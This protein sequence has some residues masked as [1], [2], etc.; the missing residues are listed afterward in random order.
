M[1]QRNGLYGTRL[2]RRIGRQDSADAIG[3]SVKI[4]H[5][6]ADI[7]CSV[8]HQKVNHR[9]PCSLVDLVYNATP[10]IDTCF[11]SRKASRPSIP[12]SRPHPLCYTP[13]KGAVLT[14]G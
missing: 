10:P 12:S 9:L 3:S 14:E 7:V 5:R 1:A 8:M 6:Y 11:V 4:D 13:P 2:Q